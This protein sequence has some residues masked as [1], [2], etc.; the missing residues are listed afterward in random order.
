MDE[1]I[2]KIDAMLSK[3]KAFYT[4]LGE[5]IENGY[6]NDINDLE[7][8]HEVVDTFYSPGNISET[9][10]EP[11][12]EPEEKLNHFIMDVSSEDEIDNISLSSNE[13]DIEDLSNSD[14]FSD[15]P[16]YFSMYMKQKNEYQESKL[17]D[18]IDNYYNNPVNKE[19]IIIFNNIENHDDK[20]K[21]FI[22]S[23]FIF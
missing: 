5:V 19:N 11:E 1:S 8:L 7:Y 10:S 6:N 22:N 4:Y 14:L 18:S 16:D 2:D 17:K 20:F 21:R 15:P 23:S 12:S 13:T 9:D 3:I